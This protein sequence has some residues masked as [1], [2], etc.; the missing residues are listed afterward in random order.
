MRNHGIGL[1]HVGR[2]RVLNAQTFLLWLCCSF[3]M[4]AIH[5]LGFEPR[6]TSGGVTDDYQDALISQCELKAGP[7]NASSGSADFLELSSF[8]PAGAA[9]ALECSRLAPPR[10]AFHIPV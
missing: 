5:S 2:C 6:A 7:S 9:I 3:E 1:Y 4:T 10:R 8:G